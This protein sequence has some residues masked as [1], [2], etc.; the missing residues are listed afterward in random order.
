M[1]AITYSGFISTSEK[2]TKDRLNNSFWEK[3]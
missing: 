3:F 1:E 2:E